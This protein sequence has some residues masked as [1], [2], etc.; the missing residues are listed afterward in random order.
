MKLAWLALPLMAAACASSVDWAK[1]GA[2]QSA[3]DSDLQ[4]CRVAAQNVAALPRPRTAPKSQTT[5]S[6]ID[7]DRQLEEAQLV[8]DCMQKR[9]YRLVSK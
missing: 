3:I 8:Q 5:A 9:G 4:G 6:E 7:A 2:A 1:P